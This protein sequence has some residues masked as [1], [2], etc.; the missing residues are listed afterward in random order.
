VTKTGSP[1]PA[2]TTCWRRR[3]YL[4]RGYAQGKTATLPSPIFSTHVNLGV[5]SPTGSSCGLSSRTRD[6]SR[7]SSRAGVKFPGIAT[8]NGLLGAKGD[9]QHPARIVAL[10]RR[11][12]SLTSITFCWQPTL[13][14]SYGRGVLVANNYHGPSNTVI[15]LPHTSLL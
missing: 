4:M 2:G 10:H 5:L 14:R 12:V 11:R 15:P 7:P 8:R 3:G 9:R 6:P 13:P 1:Q